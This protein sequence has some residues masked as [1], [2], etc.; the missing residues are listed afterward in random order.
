[1]DF[2][3][4]WQV[5]ILFLSRGY[6][7]HTYATYALFYIYNYIIMDEIVLIGYEQ[8]IALRNDQ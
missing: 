3:F 6:K 8:L 7:I 1:M 4:E 2:I 5:E